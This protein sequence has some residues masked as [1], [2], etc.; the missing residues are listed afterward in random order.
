MSFLTPPSHSPF[1]PLQP[2]QTP[3]NPPAG[4]LIITLVHPDPSRSPATA[5]FLLCVPDPCL[6]AYYSALFIHRHFTSSSSTG[7]IRWRH[8]HIELEL[9][10]KDGL[11]ATSG[12]RIGISLHWIGNVMKDVNEGRRTMDSAAQ[13]FKGVIL[14]EMVHTIQHD[15]F[16]STP[17]WLIEGFAD[18]V[19]LLARLDPPHWKKAGQGNPDKGYET[20]Y[21][22]VAW[23]L[24]Y[25]TGQEPPSVPYTGPD[26]YIPVN[27]A[28]PPPVTTQTPSQALPTRIAQDGQPNSPP[29]PGPPASR[30]RPR[31]PFP[32][33]VHVIDSRLETSRWSDSWWVEMT[34]APLDVLWREY[35]E[36]Y[37]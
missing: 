17:G 31:G 10:D 5:F 2:V 20:G 19:R 23:F 7:P 25:L 11:A 21:D 8:Q 30:P 36:Y 37:S 18:Y 12:G 27:F 9:E 34:G 35:L 29:P 3:T 33:L 28:I 14:H 15:G 22:V 6:F 4:S 24:C 16:G 26:A 1:Q 13:E 32:G